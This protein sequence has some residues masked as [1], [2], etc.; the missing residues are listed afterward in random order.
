MDAV[1]LDRKKDCFLQLKEI[2]EGTI[3]SVLGDQLM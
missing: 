3:S 1:S 2:T